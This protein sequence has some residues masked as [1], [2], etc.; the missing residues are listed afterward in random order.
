[1]DGSKVLYKPLDIFWTKKHH[2]NIWDIMKS[3]DIET[4]K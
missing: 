1:M 2:N 3:I 4:I